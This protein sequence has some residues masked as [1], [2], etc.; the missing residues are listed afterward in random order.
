M[1]EHRRYRTLNRLS[2]YRRYCENRCRLLMVKPQSS[3][4]REGFITLRSGDVFRTVK[5]ICSRH[6]GLARNDRERR[7]QE[8]KSVSSRWSP[9]TQFLCTVVSFLP[10]QARNR[11]KRSR[12]HLRLVSGFDVE[13]RC[14]Q[15]GQQR[16]N[17]GPWSNTCENGRR[18]LP[19][20]TN[21]LKRRG[22]NACAAQCG[23]RF[24]YRGA[25]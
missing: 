6:G 1:E 19:R 7:E 23:W 22:G 9:G 18:R 10:A 8:A 11:G 14:S 13:G 16:R 15:H 24:S 25:G 21:G 20:Q 17:T 2:Q 3:N 4:N 5:I 12:R